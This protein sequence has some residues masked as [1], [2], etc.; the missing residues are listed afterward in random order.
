VAPPEEAYDQLDLVQVRDEE[1]VT[2]DVVFPLWT[3]AGV[4]DLGL[5]LRLFERYKHAFETAITGLRTA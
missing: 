2:F 1:M 4:T 3:D 5:E